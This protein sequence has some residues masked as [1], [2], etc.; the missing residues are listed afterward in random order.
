MAVR[1][2]LDYETVSVV[3]AYPLMKQSDTMKLTEE[4]VTHHATYGLAS[5]AGRTAV[6]AGK[7]TPS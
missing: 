2:I 3:T 5:A 4:Q 6:G 7:G 1:V